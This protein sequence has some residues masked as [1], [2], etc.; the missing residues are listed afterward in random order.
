MIES[1]LILIICVVFLIITIGHS[2]KES[3]NVTKRAAFNKEIKRSIQDSGFITTKTFYLTDN[4]SIDKANEMKLFFDIDEKNKKICFVDYDQKNKTIIDFTDF[5]GYDVIEGGGTSSM[6]SGF[7]TSYG[8]RAYGGI[9]TSS[10][11]DVVKNMQ[12]IVRLN[13]INNSLVTYTLISDML[14]D[15][16][17]AKSSKGYKQIVADLQKAI[18]FFEIVK[19]ENNIKQ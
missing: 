10:S 7:G 1:I 15:G 19:R 17:L 14:F 16:G 13:D 11:N 8:G 4:I 3:N 18:A 9:A 6:G 12:L 2:A 5:I